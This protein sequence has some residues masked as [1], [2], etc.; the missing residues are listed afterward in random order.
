MKTT[1]KHAL[2]LCYD[3]ILQVSNGKDSEFQSSKDQ[4]LCTW[5]R[6][7]PDMYTME[8]HCS[9]SKWELRSLPVIQLREGM[10]NQDKICEIFAL[11]NTIGLVLLKLLA[12]LTLSEKKCSFLPNSNN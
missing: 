6:Y 4:M 3:A 5:T 8:H 11:N 2:P 10:V 9:A 1:A 12:S 7:S